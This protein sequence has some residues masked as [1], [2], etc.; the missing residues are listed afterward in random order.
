M[1]IEVFDNPGETPIELVDTFP[2]NIE[3][4]IKREDLIHPHISGNKWRKLKYNLIE[5]TKLGYQSILTFG[6]AYSNHLYATAAAGAAIGID[7]IGVVRGELVKPLNDTLKRV[8]GWGM[9][10]HPISRHT[11]QQKND[12]TFL[13]PT[14]KVVW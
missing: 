4:F 12:D 9:K 14:K 6:G 7:T 10:L 2:G 1:S 3:L 8:V 5:A 11:Y 13:T